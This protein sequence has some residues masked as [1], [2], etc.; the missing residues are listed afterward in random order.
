MYISDTFSSLVLCWIP[1]TDQKKLSMVAGKIG[2]FT[3]KAY[4]DL[5]LST[6]RYTASRSS[7][8][9]PKIC[10]RELT[11]Q[12]TALETAGNIAGDLDT[13]LPSLLGSHS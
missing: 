6:S 7:G 12:E 13:N 8:V 11:E 1:I 4:P 10:I 2:T 3:S 5:N 9:N